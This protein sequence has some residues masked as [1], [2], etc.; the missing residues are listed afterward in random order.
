MT[1]AERSRRARENRAREAADRTRPLAASLSAIPVDAADAGG[2]DLLAA[3]GE[4]TIGIAMDLHTAGG[5][6]GEDG[7]IRAATRS[8]LDAL[9]EDFD[10][11]EA[12]QGAIR[13]A[14]DEIASEPQAQEAQT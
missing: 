8:L 12:A 7:A 6:A 9:A 4:A 10:S 2:Q 14:L 1:Q 3:L 13:Q 11:A 5:D